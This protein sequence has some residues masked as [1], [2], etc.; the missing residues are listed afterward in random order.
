MWIL[1][2]QKFTLNIYIKLYFQQNTKLAYTLCKN[3]NAVLRLKTTKTCFTPKVFP[4]AFWLNAYLSFVYVNRKSTLIEIATQ[5]ATP[6]IYIHSV[7]ILRKS[8]IYTPKSSSVCFH[9]QRKITT[10]HNVMLRAIYP[11]C[12]CGRRRM[13]TR[14]FKV[15]MEYLKIK[16]QLPGTCS[17]WGVSPR[18]WFCESIPPI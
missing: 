17:I 10:T 4:R 1:L 5:R 13:R 15:E 2:E 8:T 7:Y 16:A 6:S 11:I 18:S 12:M 3:K 14:R 9:N